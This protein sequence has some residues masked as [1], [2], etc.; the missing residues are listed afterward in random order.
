MV[1]KCQLQ[2]FDDLSVRDFSRLIERGDC[3]SR[4]VRL[5]GKNFKELQASSG[6]SGLRRPHIALAVISITLAF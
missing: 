1:E 6:A 4:Y 2:S 5:R 3:K